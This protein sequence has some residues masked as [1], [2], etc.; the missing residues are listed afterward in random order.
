MTPQ[1]KYELELWINGVMVADIS[2]LA[3][4]RSYTI[5]RNDS[6]ELAFTLHV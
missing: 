3:K 1:I 5:K 2:K 6:E 4:D